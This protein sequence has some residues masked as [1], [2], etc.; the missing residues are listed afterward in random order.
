MIS[1]DK[2]TIYRTHRKLVRSIS[3]MLFGIDFCGGDRHALVLMPEN[4]V[5]F[6]FCVVDRRLIDEGVIGTERVSVWHHIPNCG[7]IHSLILGN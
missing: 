2:K 7:D 3:D 1:S 6:Q 5:W 4:D